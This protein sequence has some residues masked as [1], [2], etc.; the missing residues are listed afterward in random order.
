[1]NIHSD[2][3]QIEKEII[4]T[5]RDI[6]KHPE[7]GF[8]EVRTSQLIADKLKSYGLDVQTGVGKTGVIGTLKGKAK[9]PVIALRA[10]MDA[11]PIQET[12]TND[13]KSVHDGVMHACGH[14]GHVAMLLGAAQVLTQM[15]DKIDGTIKFIFQPSEE[16]EG[17]AKY[18]IND[19]CLEGVDEIYGIHLWNYL[20]LGKLGGQAGPILAAADEFRIEIKGV[21]GHGA[22]PQGTIDAVVVGTQL[23]TALQTIVSRNTNP[24]DSTVVTVGKFHAGSN[25]NIISAEAHMEGTAR[26]YTEENRTMIKTRMKE[27]IKGLETSTGAKIELDYIDGYPPTINHQKA[28]QI[29][30]QSAEK[31]TGIDTTVEHKSMGGEDFSFYLQ[32]IPGSFLF[33]GASPEGVEPGEIPH[34]SSYYNFNEKALLTGASILIQLIE[35]RLI[36]KKR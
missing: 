32:K 15:S 14:D 29:L 16:R 21:G 10:D 19:G 11:L 4:E 26:A 3:R 20:P 7:L 24:L 18:M 17:G 22:A 5:R 34:H 27:I 33:V 35:D 30:R 2:I 31:I 6:H 12:G 23:V 28:F 36:Y 9:T 1:M 13:Y 8:N 25:F